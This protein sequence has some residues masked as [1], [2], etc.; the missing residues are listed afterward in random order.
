MGKAAVP[1]AIPIRLWRWLKAQFAADRLP[2]AGTPPGWRPPRRAL[3]W[4]I[5]LAVASLA[6][7]FVPLFDVLGYDFAFALGLVAAPAAVDVGHAVGRRWRIALAR[8][9]PARVWHLALRAAATGLGL[10]VLPLLISLAQALRVRNCNLEAGLAFYLLLPVGTMLFGAPLGALAALLFPR[11]GRLVAILL[12]LGSIAWTLVRLYNDPPAFALDPF[13]GYFP[14]PIY[15]EALSPP[16]RLVLFRLANLVWVATALALAAAIERVRLARRTSAADPQH[17]DRRA[18]MASLLLA[19]VLTSGALGLYSQRGPLGFAVDKPYLLSVLRRQ[20]QSPHFVLASDPTGDG[21]PEDRALVLRDLEF[22]YDQL[23]HILGAQPAGP[24]TVY[25]FPSAEA[26]KSLVGAGGTLYAKPWKREIFVQADRFPAR[27]LRHELAHV[28]AGAFGDPIFGISLAWRWPLPR[29]SSGMVEGI[30]EA[31]DYGD[32]DGRATVHQEA[33]A[34]ILAGL[35]PP[36]AKVVGAGFTTVAGARAYTIAGSFTH[37]L[38]A[39]FGADKLRAIYRS[40]GDFVG[41]FGQDLAALE[42]Q[43]REFLER[44]PVDDREKARAKERY[45]RPAIFQKVCARDI[46]AR[47][48][49]ARGHL[50]SLPD[51]AV[52]IFASV[53]HDDPDEPGYRLNLAEAQVAAGQPAPALATAQ[54][55]TED[56]TLTEPLRARAANLAASIHYHA[57]HFTEAGAALVQAQTF[58]TDEGEQRTAIARL[59]AIADPTARA[60]LGRILFGDSPIRGVEPGLVIYLSDQFARAFPDEALGPYMVGRQL[61]FRDPKLALA[62]LRKACPLDDGA[63]A[64]PLGP[65]FTAECRRLLGEAAFRAGDLDTSAVAWERLRQE[66]ASVGDR[67]RAGDFL[68]RIAWQ[69]R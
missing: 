52:A 28:F 26:K 38:L 59:R 3:I 64:V 11:R 58:A 50:Y 63:A 48:E 8:S 15:D 7:G 47:I 27:H 25:L 34:M 46:A 51:E 31:A 55:M 33:R 22:R 39:T 67:L 32:P 19:A 61:S 60:T 37:F 13:G 2:T 69:R 35:A 24:V 41:V 16:L 6:L 4:G 12:P 68:E 54:A 44:Q 62:P 45:R 5:V 66:G 42:R 43:W 10:L 17:A 56:A 49:T 57:Q 9:E 14:G 36:L 29:L 23:T 65:V 20:S 53:C 30:A 18:L 21:T 1:A 40:G